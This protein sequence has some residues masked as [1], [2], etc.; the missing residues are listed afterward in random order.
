[1][2]EEAAIL[3]I[4]KDLRAAVS[5]ILQGYG[6]GQGPVT[7]TSA[8][9]YR[10]CGC[11]ELLLQFDQKEQKSFLGPRKDYWDFL[12]T[13][14]R[15]QRVDMEPIHFV[16]SQDKLKTP[17]GKGRAFIRFCLA[18]GQLAEALQ[19][20][21]LNPEL[22]REWYGPRSPLLCPERQE[23]ILDSLY[24]LNGVA[25]ELDLQQPD[26]DGAWPMFSESRCSS[27]TQTQ[28]R[29]PRK[30]KDAPKKIPAAY[31]RPENVQIEDS[32][33]NQAVC[34]QDA[35]SGQQLAGL[36]RSQQQRHL[37]FFLEK[38]GGN[39]RRH[40][41]PQSMWEPEEEELQLDQEEGTPWI[42]MFLG[43]STPSTQGQGKG[44]MGT[45]KEVIGMEAEGTG[46]LLG[47][48][49]QRTTEE[50]HE[51]EPEWSHVQKL[52][53]P[54]PRG[55]IAGTVSGSRQGSG[56]SSILGEP[57]VL[58]G[59]TTKE[60]STMENPQVQTEV[61]LVAR[62]E[63]QA[64]V[65][66]QDEIKSLRLGLRKAEEQAQH[67]EQLLRKQE[68]ELQAL[69]E[70]LSRC[71]EERAE[72]Q[73]QLEQ[74]QQ[75]A[76]RRDAMYQEELGGQ[77]DLVQAMKRRVLELI[78]EKDRLWQRLQHLSSMA[79]GCCV[80]CSKIFGRLSRRYPCRLCGGLLCH[81]CSADY[82]KR[83]RCCPPCAQ[84]GEAQV[85]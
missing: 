6:D 78:Q 85:T 14:L 27:S 62:R 20:C 56:D 46:V 50:T 43:N 83:D 49:G 58:Q 1:M 13:A 51:K 54:S 60:D 15:R 55:T 44:A 21:L 48:E 22:T 75:E 37:P 11:L 4:T 72:L 41:Y 8:E 47:A 52:L 30:T 12:C 82:K 25:F 73:A 80:A 63:E 31:G 5:A 9:L 32:H 67:Q 38:K 74:K 40:R 16:R 53:M 68:G 79:P 69:R 61:T 35:P 59:L 64:E 65:S 2:A 42:E 70:Q 29:R 33:T 28:G 26:L 18:R 71:Q 19:L 45:Q 84:G 7:D 10:L 24:A 81:A 23:D 17:L 39:S 76:E 36:P 57:W 34:L 3:K 77:R 66:L